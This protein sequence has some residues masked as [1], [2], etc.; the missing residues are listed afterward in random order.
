MEFYCKYYR[1]IIRRD[2][3]WFVAGCLRSDSHIVFDRAYDASGHL[4]EFFVPPV[5]E[6]SFLRV[7]GLFQQRGYILELTQLPN[8]IAQQQGVLESAH[9]STLS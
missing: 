8:R 3:V 7:M 6:E 5:H 4:F 9:A 1:A 2:K